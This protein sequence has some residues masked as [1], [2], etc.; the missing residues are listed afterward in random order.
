MTT[1]QPGG[2][3]TW[4]SDAWGTVNELPPDVATAFIETLELARTEPGFYEAR[5]AMLRDLGLASG[6][7]VLEGGSGTGA[8]LPDVLEL[9]GQA[10]QVLGVDP[11]IAFVEAA[12]RRAADLGAAN[13]R[14]E[15][16][17][18]RALPMADAGFDAAFCDKILIHAGP[19]TVALRELARV[20]RPGGRVG[21]VEWWP[22]PTIS[23]TH[24][25]TLARFNEAW[26]RPAYDWAASGN[27]ARYF[28]AAGLVDVRRRAFL[29]HADSLDEHPFWRNLLMAT[30]TSRVR[31]G[32]LS[33]EDGQILGA[34]WEELNRQGEF[35]ISSVVQTAVGIRP[36]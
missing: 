34:D 16:G 11:T 33:E 20:V 5:R 21:A 26:M 6:S 1:A 2:T 17:D 18:I 24:P 10:G 12:R 31:A 32:L 28:H 3:S 36:A 14:Y 7:T 27:L 9:L 23:T 25:E 22:A 19:A 29:G 15:V 13:A 30:V 4:G 35:S 8:A